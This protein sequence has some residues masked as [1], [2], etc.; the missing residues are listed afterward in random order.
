MAEIAALKDYVHKEICKDAL[1]K[2][3][4]DFCWKNLSFCDQFKIL[5]AA[6]EHAAEKV[7]GGA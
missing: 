4:K 2:E 1:D 5:A 6:E 3:C 7:Q